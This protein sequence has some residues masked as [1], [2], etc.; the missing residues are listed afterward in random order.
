MT[1]NQKIRDVA[2]MHFKSKIVTAK[3]KES[4][5]IKLH[6][7]SYKVSINIQGILIIKRT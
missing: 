7:K 5:T 1:E 3:S 4:K 6:T 2:I